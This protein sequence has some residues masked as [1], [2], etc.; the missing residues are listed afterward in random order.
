MTFFRVATLFLFAFKLTLFFFI[1]NIKLIYIY[2]NIKCRVKITSHEILQ[3]KS[4]RRTH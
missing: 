1:V 2:R 4:Q 3:M